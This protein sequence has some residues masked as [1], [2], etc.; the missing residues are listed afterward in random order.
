MRPER[1]PV[2]SA[3]VHAVAAGAAAY[4]RVDGVV[5]AA[6][7]KV[8]RGIEASLTR[9]FSDAERTEVSI[10]IYS[11]LGQVDHNDRPLFAWEQAFFARHLPKPPARVLV[12]GAGAGREVR[13]LL[14]LGYAVDAFEPAAVAYGA[15]EARFGTAGTM[16]RG[17]YEDLRSE[18]ALADLRAHRYDAVVC[19][20]SSLGHVLG[21]DTR[22]DAMR[23][24]DRLAPRGPILT[25]FWMG[26]TAQ[27]VFQ[28]HAGFMH[29]FTREEVLA[30]G[31]VVFRETVFGE[32]IDRGVFPHAAFIP[33][34]D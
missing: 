15:L 24:L 10:A 4:A 34:R 5:L 13:A 12:G 11:R 20:W 30:L 22:A 26:E 14:D 8:R 9:A 28:S 2:R 23:A 16:R 18:G 1:G 27:D 32:G 29:R 17:T 3:I 19:G 31:D 6:R 7:E 25:S 21:E 33:A